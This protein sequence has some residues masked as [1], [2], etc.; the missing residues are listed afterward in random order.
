MSNPKDP[1]AMTDQEI[2]EAVAEVMGWENKWC[3]SCRN[4]G[5]MHG[6]YRSP[7]R[8]CA[9]WR[10]LGMTLPPRPWNPLTD[11]NHTM[12][13]VKKLTDKDSWAFSLD[14][15]FPKWLATFDHMESDVKV[16]IK[17]SDPQRAICLATLK[18]VSPQ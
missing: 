9:N 11:W 5:L 16:V 2:I 14:T 3:R 12:S 4:T 7:C 1:S 17:D 18:A 10:A 8:E 15:Y 13:V 6:K